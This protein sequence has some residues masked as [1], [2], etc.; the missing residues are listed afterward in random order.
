[1]H[2]IYAK[3]ICNADH[4]KIVASALVRQYTAEEVMLPALYEM[5]NAMHTSTQPRAHATMDAGASIALTPA[6]R[7]E[8]IDM[9]N[10]GEEPDPGELDELSRQHRQQVVKDELARYYTAAGT[11]SQDGGFAF[12]SSTDERLNAGLYPI[13]SE[14]ARL[15]LCI[16]ASKIECERIFSL[17]G[18]VTHDRHASP[19]GCGDDVHLGFHQQ[20]RGR[21]CHGDTAFQTGA[22]TGRVVVYEYP[23]Y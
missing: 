19:N 11:I 10:D 22:D 8:D 5:G 9:V 7:R 12:P 13:V 15:S 18:L 21:C 1:M 6:N 23:I 3:Y 14:L 17:A 2:G 16:H 4:V 20:E